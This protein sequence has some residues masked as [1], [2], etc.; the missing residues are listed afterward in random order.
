MLSEIHEIGPN[1]AETLRRWR[2]NVDAQIE[3]VRALGYDEHFERTWH[4]YLAFCET[5]FRTRALRDVQ[6][7]FGKKFGVNRHEPRLP[8]GPTRAQTIAI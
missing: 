7:V 5:A 8:D 1:Y 6:I 4:F 3:Q 2:E